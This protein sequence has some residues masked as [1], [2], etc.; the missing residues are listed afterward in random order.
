[1]EEGDNKPANQ[2]GKV[3][4]TSEGAKNHCIHCDKLHFDECWFK[5][6]PRCHNCHKLGHI[7]RDCRGKKEK[8][9]QHVNFVNQVNDTLIM[10]Y[11]CNNV[12]VKK[13]EDIWY[14]D[15]GCSNYMI[16]REDLLVD[17]DRTITAKVEMGI[18][19][20]IEVIGKGNLVIDTKMG[21][22]YIKEV[23][24]IPGL[25]ENLL[26]VRQM[27][28]HSYFLVFGGTIAEIYDDGSMLNLIARVPMKGNKSFPLRLKPEMQVALKAS[29]Y[30]SS[31]IWHKRLGHLH[32]GSLKQLKEHDLVL[33]LPDLEMTIEICE[34]C[35]LGKH[36]RDAFPNE[37]SWR[38]SLPLELIHS[39]ICGPMQ[40]STQ[41]GNRYFLTFIDDC[42]RMCWVYFLRNKSEVFS[43]FKKFKLTVELQSG[44]KLKKLRSDRGGEYVSVEFRKFCEEMG[45]ERQLTVAY[46]PQQNGVAE[47]KNRTI[48]EMAK[49]MMIEKGVRFEHWAE[50]VNTAVYILNKCPTKSLD[51]KTYFEAYGGRKPGIKHL[52]I[53]GSVCY[54][55]IPR[56]IRQKLDETSTKCIF[57]GYDTCEKGYRLYDPISKKIIVSRDVIVDENAC[58]DW[59]SQS[60][61]TISASILGKK[62]CKQIVEGNSSDKS[63]VNDESLASSSETN[64]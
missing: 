47:R 50:A 30:Q 11:V 27:M 3:A 51:K 38:A 28:E 64:E 49:C 20:L 60:E 36:C 25:K 40:T 21:R 54:A 44:Y 6:M 52:N 23:M 15:S 26:S 43:T 14:V 18:G 7:A 61:K 8:T 53:F 32:L 29:V 35:A 24:L 5:D 55:Y 62:M 41:V 2:T 19:Q 22:R 31:T 48:V 12:T 42:T 63:D 46:T 58:W 34:G 39:D 17:I 4:G 13:S 57:L 59:K 56:P 9:N 45:M 16:G 37:P 33:G 1:M 10:F